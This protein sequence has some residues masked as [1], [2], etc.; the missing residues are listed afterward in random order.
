MLGHV[1]I[2]FM[3]LNIKMLKDRIRLCCKDFLTFIET[4][5][6]T[7]ERKCFSFYKF[8]VNLDN[9]KS[10]EYTLMK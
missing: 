3:P 6:E 8:S 7:S 4:E 2:L 1:K 10:L 9:Q 5:G